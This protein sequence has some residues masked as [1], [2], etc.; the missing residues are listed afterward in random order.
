VQLYCWWLCPVKIAS[1]FGVTALAI[2][3]AGPA[4]TRQSSGPA[5]TLLS[6]W[7]SST[8]LLVFGER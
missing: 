8:I 4:T 5:T 6:P 1:T 2:A 3:V 7:C